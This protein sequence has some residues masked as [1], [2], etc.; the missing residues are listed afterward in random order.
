MPSSLSSS[1][2]SILRPETLVTNCQPTP[3]NFPEEQGPQLYRGG[4]LKFRI[5]RVSSKA[6]VLLLPAVIT[7]LRR[8][9]RLRPRVWLRVWINFVD[10]LNL[11]PISLVSDTAR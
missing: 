4:S 2:G 5:C 11:L 1:L 10:I 9:L 8:V 6:N 7:D 3:L